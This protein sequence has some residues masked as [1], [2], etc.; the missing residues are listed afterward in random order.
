MELEL[1]GFKEAPVTTVTP[2]GH[3]L[4]GLEGAGKGCSVFSSSPF[5]KYE[6]Q[7]RG[8]LRACAGCKH[9]R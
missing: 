4:R 6:N 2:R 9:D 5:D 8:V 3:W 7:S 1:L